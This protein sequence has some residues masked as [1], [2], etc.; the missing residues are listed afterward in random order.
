MEQ[1]TYTIDMAPDSRWEFVTPGAFA[2]EKLLYMQEVG[3]FI[4]GP[5]YT[6]K[7]EGLDSYLIKLTLSGRGILEY[8]GETYPVEPG[9]F[10]LIDCRKP[11]AYY[12]DPEVGHWDVAWVHFNG[13]TAAAYYEAFTRAGEA[14][15]CRDRSGKMET[16]LATLLHKGALPIGDAGTDIAVS[17]LLTE[18][19]AAV[20]YSAGEGDT[21]SYPAFIREATRYLQTHYDEPV[22]LALLA[23]ETNVSKFHLQ[24]EFTRYLGVSPGAYLR[25]VRLNRAKELLRGTDFSVGETAAAVGM[26][27]SYFV[28]CFRES[29]GLPPGEYRKVWL[30]GGLKP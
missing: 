6:T 20:V 22:T 15:V 8:C 27:C 25:G 26:E 7:R 13:V 3:R 18:L 28:R 1:L 14:P 5:R 19:L 23:R 11:Q 9:S 17:A 21:P 4:S 29:E 16:I 24:R 30:S 12:T 10:F 2:K